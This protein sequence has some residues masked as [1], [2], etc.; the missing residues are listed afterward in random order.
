MPRGRKRKGAGR[1]S[2]WNAGKTEAVKLPELI[3]PEVMEFVR[4]IDRDHFDQELFD[5][6]RLLA[7]KTIDEKLKTLQEIESSY[8][9]KQIA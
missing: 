4:M 7:S 5:G 1:K 9:Y 6:D 8:N 2:G 3:I